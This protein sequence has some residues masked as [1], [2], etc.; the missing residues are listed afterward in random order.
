ML[1]TK[2]DKLLFAV[3]AIM[4]IA[5]AAVFVVDRLKQQDPVGNFELLS[6][7]DLDG[8]ELLLS[9]ELPGRKGSPTDEDVIAVSEPPVPDVEEQR[10]VSLAPSTTPSIDDS[11]DDQPLVLSQED[12]ISVNDSGWES[13]D[14]VRYTAMNTRLRSAPGTD[15]VEVIDL[16]P[17]GEKINVISRND[18]WSKVVDSKGR[19]GYILSSLLVKNKP[20]D[21]VAVNRT[22]YTRVDLRMRETAGTDGSYMLTIPGGTKLTEISVQ[23]SWSQVELADGSKG[24]VNNEYLTANQPQTT[25]T[26]ATTKSTS[27]PVRESTSPA[28]EP[29][30]KPT[31]EPAE[32]KAKAAESA[33]TS[34]KINLTES[35]RRDVAAL[36]RLEGGGESRACQKMIVE[37]IFN[38][39]KSRGGSIS[40][41]IYAKGLFTVADRI[42]GTTPKAIQYEIVDEVC[43]DGVF[44]PSSVL[45]FRY[46]YYHSF[47]TPYTCIGNTYFSSR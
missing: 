42:S 4:C 21:S 37:V 8:E 6:K 18:S 5:V 15:E 25:R 14:L 23:G 44:I 40:D 32:T 20:S 24:Y 41:T 33:S 16:L 3:A 34:M 30:A 35:E 12:D 47:G 10:S 45:Y 27:K 36:L 31:P 39:W 17:S 19:E 2:F 1:K 11:E 13:C 26:A 29:T 46:G 7:S 43:R 28:S 38:Q 22:R 9:N